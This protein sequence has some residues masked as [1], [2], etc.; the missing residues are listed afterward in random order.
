MQKKELAI[1]LPVTGNM[2]FALAVVLFGFK[3]HLTTQNFDIFVY[4]QDVSDKEKEL[5]TSILPLEFIPYTIDA[6][7]IN[8]IALKKYSELAFA[9][10][11]CFDYLK[12]YKKALWLDTDILIQKNLDELLKI[13][14]EIAA[15]QTN[16]WTGFNFYKPVEGYDMDVNYFNPGILLVSD[17]IKNPETLKKWCY[18]KTYEWGDN[19]ICSDQSILNL[20]FQE[21]NLEVFP[22]EEKYNCHPDKPFVENAVIVH[23]YA[24]YKFWN[25]YTDFQK[26]NELYAKWLKMG[27]NPFKG[28]KYNFCEK[29]WVR[30]KK[31]FLPE[32]PDPRRHLRKFLVYAYNYNFVQKRQA[33]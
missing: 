1:V 18:D 30:F 4:Y 11:E 7:K 26:W 21:F 19:L 13:D 12:T 10:Y 5:L 24:Q 29:L 9:R 28:K 25:F 23:P 27:G 32:A 6:E 8:T 31:K 22:L 15:W 33:K 16:V 3:E 14:A 17:K 20:L 2:T